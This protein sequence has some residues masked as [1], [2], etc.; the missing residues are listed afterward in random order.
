MKQTRK[1]SPNC[2]LMANENHC[3]NS[4]ADELF[5]F[6]TPMEGAELCSSEEGTEEP[7]G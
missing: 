3:G 7:G 6:L 4:A 5:A 1:V 2:Y